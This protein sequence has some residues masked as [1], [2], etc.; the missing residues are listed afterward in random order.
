MTLLKV[1]LSPVQILAADFRAVIN[2]SAYVLF[3]TAFTVV[4]T[5]AHSTDGLF[6]R[7]LLVANELPNRI[8]PVKPVETPILILEAFTED[9]DVPKTTLPVV[10]VE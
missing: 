9:P 3:T 4:G 7:I 5:P 1:L 8:S 2:P 6:S 10:A